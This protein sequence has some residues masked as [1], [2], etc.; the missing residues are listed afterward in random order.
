MFTERNGAGSVDIV[1]QMKYDILNSN[2]SIKE[3]KKNLK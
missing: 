1:S 2:L 3:G